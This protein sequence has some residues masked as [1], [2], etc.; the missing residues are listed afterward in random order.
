MVGLPLKSLIR[1]NSFYANSM[2][3]LLLF[4][5]VFKIC[6]I[7]KQQTTIV[8]S[9]FVQLI[10]RTSFQFSDLQVSLHNPDS[11]FLQM[12]K[13]ETSTITSPQEIIC[14]A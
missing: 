6:I 4:Y 3:L 9:L 14:I 10:M 8:F 5:I 12:L 1:H 11:F 7:F 13:I 2:A